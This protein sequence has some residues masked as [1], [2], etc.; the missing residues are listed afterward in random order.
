MQRP[1]LSSDEELKEVNFAEIGIW[2]AQHSRLMSLFGVPER[3]AVS[4]ALDGEELITRQNGDVMVQ[5]NGAVIPYFVASVSSGAAFVR[6]DLEVPVGEGTQAITLFFEPKPTSGGRRWLRHFIDTQAAM[7]MI[8]PEATPFIRN[9]NTVFYNGIDDLLTC[10]QAL[11]ETVGKINEIYTSDL[12]SSDDGKLRRPTMANISSALLNQLHF[13]FENFGERFKHGGAELQKRVADA[14]GPFCLLNDQIH[15]TEGALANKDRAIASAWW[16]LHCS[17]LPDFYRTLS[18]DIYSEFTLDW[19][20]GTMFMGYHTLGKDILAAFWN[21]DMDLFRRDEIRPQRISSS[22]I[23]LFL[24]P[25]IR[26]QMKDLEAWWKREGIDQ[27]GFQ[28]GDSRNAIGYI[29]VASLIRYGLD[30]VSIKTRIKGCKTIL[31][32]SLT[33]V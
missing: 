22:E 8:A 25:D 18:N 14:Y 11:A 26:G 30:E 24:G 15:A 4:Q 32:V 33:Q 7:R 29:P 1:A 12:P 6:I 3:V 16:A 19:D 21:N 17:F 5:R 9:F 31:G 27:F 23:F 10:I 20:F 13:E 28:L 2:K